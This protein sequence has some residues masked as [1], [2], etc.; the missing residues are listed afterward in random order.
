MIAVQS[1]LLQLLLWH[2]L[3]YDQKKVQYLVGV[4]DDLE[5]GVGLGVIRVPVRVV[6][7]GL[8]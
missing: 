2:T 4:S 7:P 3:Q 8:K 6:V 1:N 5:F